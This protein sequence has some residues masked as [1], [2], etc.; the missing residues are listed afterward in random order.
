MVA[1][2]RL[3]AGCELLPQC[4]DLLAQ[5]VPSLDRNDFHIGRVALEQTRRGL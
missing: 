1:R 3:L 4:C 5:T 2:R